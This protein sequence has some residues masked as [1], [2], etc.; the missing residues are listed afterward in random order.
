M[1]Q[2]FT[3]FGSY[4]RLQAVLPAKAGTTNMAREIA[5]HR[6][7]SVHQPDQ[8]VVRRVR[9]GGD[10]EA[11]EHEQHGEETAG[12]EAEKERVDGERLSVRADVMRR[13]KDRAAENHGQDR[14]SL[15]R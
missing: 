3:G 4:F 14:R 2:E 5:D 1:E 8:H 6:T 10:A 11:A 12:D 13:R 9:P 7:L 15:V